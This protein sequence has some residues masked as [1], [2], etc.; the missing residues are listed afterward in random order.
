[1]TFKRSAKH[2]HSRLQNGGDLDLENELEKLESSS[3][4][5][6]QELRFNGTKEAPTCMDKN[7]G[8]AH[9]C[10]ETPKG[11]IACECRPGFQLTKNSRDCKL[12][13]NY[14]NGGCQ[15]ICEEMDHGPR[16]SCH[17]KF[18]LHSD[19][20]TC[21]GLTQTPYYYPSV[22]QNL[23]AAPQMRRLACLTGPEDKTE[24]VKRRPQRPEGC[25][26]SVRVAHFPPQESRWS[27]AAEG[28]VAV[29]AAAG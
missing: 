10:R 29:A 23:P 28:W 3:D 12:T 1:M 19:G 2:Y 22:P 7:H 4:I 15:H 5:S 11:T 25:G 24:R 8:C 9:I 20:K 18:A 6:S 14:G 26:E 13:C 17:M 27:A 21:V 16:C